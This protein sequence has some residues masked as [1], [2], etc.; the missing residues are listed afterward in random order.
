[1]EN[2]WIQ[3][4]GAAEEYLPDFDREGHPFSSTPERTEELIPAKVFRDH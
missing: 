4:M 1:M 2:G 3:E